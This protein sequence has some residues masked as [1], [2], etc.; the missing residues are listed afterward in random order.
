[1]K[2]RVIAMMIMA[3][4][5][6]SVTAGPEDPSGKDVFVVKTEKKYLGAKVQVFNEAGELL[7]TQTLRNR[8]VV[9]DFGN[10]KEGTYTIRLSK[11]NKTKEFYFEKKDI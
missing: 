9:I 8:K 10:V 1:M 11:D 7:A 3:A 2:T 4:V 6:F 5:T